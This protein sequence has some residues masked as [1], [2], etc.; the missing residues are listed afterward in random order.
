MRLVTFE[1]EVN[2]AKLTASKFIHESWQISSNE[3]SSMKLAWVPLILIARV[4]MSLTSG[5]SADAEIARI[6]AIAA[7]KRGGCS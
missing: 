6:M 5:V 1:S 7:V 2:P 3:K 4:G